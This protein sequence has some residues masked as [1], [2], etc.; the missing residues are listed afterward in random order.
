METVTNVVTKV[1]RN[2]NLFSE[3]LSHG[4]AAVREN[5]PILK[6]SIELFQASVKPVVDDLGLV[7]RDAMTPLE[8]LSF[9]ALDLVLQSETFARLLELV[10]THLEAVVN[11]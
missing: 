5:L 1:T 6:R 9:V 10:N 2:L 4:W 3:M 7:I 11:A 8:A